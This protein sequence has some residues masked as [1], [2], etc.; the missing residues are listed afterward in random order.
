[1]QPDFAPS[2]VALLKAAHDAIKA[3]DPGARVVLAGLA[4]SS[5][6]DLA[7]IYRVRG[8]RSLFDIVAIHPYT[9]RPAGVLTILDNARGVM[10]HA[11]DARKPMVADEVGWN[12]SL[13]KSPDHFGVETNEAGQARKIDAVMQILTAR[14]TKLRLLSFDI[15]DWAGTEEQ[16]SYEFNFAGLFRF[17]GTGFEAKPAYRVFRR[18]SLR[19]EG[20][21]VKASA[22]RCVRRA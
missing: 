7:R 2:Y 17:T 9:A 21:R 19:L 10:A 12:S 22:T 13:G 16:G 1:M 15:Y 3:A 8:A 4:D 5:W 14:R 11:G 18:D 20:C 6:L